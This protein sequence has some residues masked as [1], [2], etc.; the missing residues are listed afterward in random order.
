M[1][2]P[3]TPDAIETLRTLD[4]RMAV[5]FQLQ[6]QPGKLWQFGSGAAYDGKSAQIEDRF[7][8]LQVR[9]VEGRNSDTV[10]T[11]IDV[12]RR[13]IH[14]P[15]RQNVA[16]LV[17][18]DDLLSTKIDPKSPIARQVAA[19]IRRA[20]DN[21]WLQ[22]FYGTAYTGETG[23]TAVP[24][25]SANVLASGSTGITKNKLISMM[26]LI[27][28]RLVD[29]EAEMPIMLIT[30]K[31]HSD[32]LKINEIT[33]RDYNPL[34]QQALQTGKVAEF[35]GFRFVTTQLGDA[36]VYPDAYTLTAAGGERINPVF[37][38]SGMHRGTWLD[39]DG[40]ID[41]LPGKNQSTQIY[42]ETVVRATR[43]N[44]DKCFQMANVEV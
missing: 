40:Y 22:G 27:H 12:E 37:V 20:H 10:T 21:R 7:D 41:R 6:E 42:G 29:V 17:D 35:M 38:P 43:L 14:K 4:F 18:K 15:K 23:A 16:V 13:W 32:L 9:E 39:F 3:G 33:S 28:I 2:V 26:E 1:T 30:A 8:D 36:R 44:E 11:D 19:A 31:Q 5:D 24:F 34:L 25:K